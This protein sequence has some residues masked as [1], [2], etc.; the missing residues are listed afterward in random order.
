MADRLRSEKRITVSKEAEKILELA[1]E[2]GASRFALV[3]F[4]KIKFGNF[5]R[6]LENSLPRFLQYIKNS[7]DKREDITRW[8]ESSRSALVCLWQYWNS[9]MDYEKEF[10]KSERSVDFFPEKTGRFSRGPKISRYAMVPDYHKVI[11]K[12]LSFLLTSIRKIFP[13]AE[14]KIFVDTSPVFEKIL[15]ARA[16]LGWI[17]KNGLLINEENGSYFFIG[18]IS[19][20]LDVG[21][22]GKNVRGMCSDC[23]LCV[24]S[25]PTGALAGDGTLNFEKCLSYWTTQAKEPAPREIIEKSEE[26]IYGCDICQEACPYNEEVKVP[27]L[28]EFGN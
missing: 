28:K 9:R 11:R 12:K 18:G 20:N 2:A 10:E 6:C 3:K 1:R 14:G 5:P 7:L 24:E 26:W 19:L 13:G 8:H 4:S 22:A 17:G 16:G 21:E 27:V 25:C 23:L 15:A